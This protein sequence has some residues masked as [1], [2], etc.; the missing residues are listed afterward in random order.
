MLDLIGNV[1]RKTIHPL[2]DL[3]QVISQDGQVAIVL[4]PHFS[5]LVVD[6]VECVI[7]MLLHLVQS[8]HRFA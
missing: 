5:E 4:L 1:G 8:V 7:H 3:D 2:A 6:A